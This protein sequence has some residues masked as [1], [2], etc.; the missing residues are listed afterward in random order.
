MDLAVLI[1]TNSENLVLSKLCFLHR[2]LGYSQMGQNQAKFGYLPIPSHPQMGDN[3]FDWPMDMASAW[4]LQE[5]C[6]R[7][8]TTQMVTAQQHVCF[9]SRVS[10]W[11]HHKTGKIMTDHGNS[12]MMEIIVFQNPG[13]WCKTPGF[14]SDPT[15]SIDFI[16]SWFHCYIYIYTYSD[17]TIQKSEYIWY[18]K[19]QSIYIYI[20]VCIYI[21]YIHMI[22][23]DIHCEFFF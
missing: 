20:Y 15:I 18:Q 14:L 10:V 5:C 22:Y 6:A 8:M 19:S 1:R 23:S 4:C 12:N 13:F 17:E 9:V 16:G 11:L 3:D 2:Y 21:I 7:L